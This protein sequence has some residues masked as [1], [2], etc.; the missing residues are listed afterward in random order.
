MIWKQIQGFNNYLIS[1]TGLIKSFNKNKK[2]KILKLHPNSTKYL[3]VWL[4]TSDYR[5]RFFVH[6]LVAIHFKKNNNNYRYIDHKNRIRT[7][8]RANNL[9]WCSIEQNLKNRRFCKSYKSK[10]LEDVPF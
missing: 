5:E 4:Y 10:K 3:R 6:K 7:D 2:G 8:N 9:R 1:N